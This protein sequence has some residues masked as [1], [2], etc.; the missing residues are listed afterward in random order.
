M[1]AKFFVVFLGFYEKAYNLF[2]GF[3]EP[4]ENGCITNIKASMECGKYI[5]YLDFFW[6]IWC[7]KVDK[8]GY[9]V[10]EWMEDTENPNNSEKVK[11]E[12]G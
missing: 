9:H 3:D 10:D 6:N 8:I 4:N 5:S 12:M 1:Q 7:S 11:Y 2:N